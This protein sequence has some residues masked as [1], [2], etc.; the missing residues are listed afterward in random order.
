LRLIAFEHSDLI[1]RL[2]DIKKKRD[3]KGHGKGGADAPDDELSDDQFMREVVNTLLP[4]IVFSDTPATRL[5]KDV[6][7]DSLLD[8]RAS[9]Q[10]EFSFKVFYRLGANLQ[11]RL[12]QAERFWLSC[13]DN[14]DA[15]FFVC[16]L[17]AALQANFRQKLS[18]KL[19]PNIMDS[20]L[21]TTAQ[22]KTRENSFGDL[23]EC[24]RTV[25][26]LAIRE[27]L[28]GNDPTLGACV[29]AFLLMSDDD[30]LHSIA[31]SQ[32]SFIDDITNVIVR[33]GHGNEPLPLPKADIKKL[34]KASYT[35]I[36]T[37]IEA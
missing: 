21:I 13:K 14:D 11:D 10:S 15:L 16:D 34:R 31:D 25:R 17:Y 27:T 30:T 23:P 4:N 5:N 36:K 2:L 9:V 7:A 24:L 37:L 22:G 3:E 12:V 26:P 6:R 29:V 20:D 1:I 32:P 19:S 33:R 28:Q 18:G 35:T 8:A